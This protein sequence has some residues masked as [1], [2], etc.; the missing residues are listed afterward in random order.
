MSYS[1]HFQPPLT[2]PVFYTLLALV[3]DSRHGYGIMSA[4]ADL[5]L[6]TVIMARG[7]IYPLLARLSQAGLIASAGYAVTTGDT[8]RKHYTLT[9][10]GL[11]LIKSDLNRLKHAIAVS[12]AN[13][14]F[15]DQLPLDIQKLFIQQGVDT[16]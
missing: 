12:E 14:L 16:G 9:E 15:I 3:R 7:T 5:S 6:G 11:I 4:V 13:G 10:Q 2:P 1:T 8:E